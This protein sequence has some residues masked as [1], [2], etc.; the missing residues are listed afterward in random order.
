MAGTLYKLDKT[1]HGEVAT[2]GDD[3]QSREAGAEAF[4]SLADRGFAMFDVSDKLIG[5]PALRAFDPEATEI[6]AV[7]RLVAG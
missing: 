5:K 4:K 1:G 7:P 6:V 3:A 2:W